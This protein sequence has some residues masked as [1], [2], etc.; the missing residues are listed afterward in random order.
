MDP[1]IQKIPALRRCSV[2][3][4]MTGYPSSALSARLETDPERDLLNL[5][6]SI[7][8]PDRLHIG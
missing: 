3:Y 6:R 5:L 7:I 4:K 2:P 8:C 1:E